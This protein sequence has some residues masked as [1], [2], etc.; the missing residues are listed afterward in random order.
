MDN[1]LL[2]QLTYV[3]YRIRLTI[4]HGERWLM[5]ASRKFRPF[6]PPCKGWLWDLAQCLFHNIVPYSFARRAPAFPLVKMFILTGERF[7]WWSSRMLPVYSIFFIIGRD[8]RAGRVLLLFCSTELPFQIINLSLHGFFK[9]SISRCMAFS[10]HQSLV[11]WLFHHLAHE[12]H[13]FS[14]ENHSRPYGHRA[15]CLLDNLP[16]LFDVQDW[17]VHPID[18]RWLIPLGADLFD[19]DLI[20]S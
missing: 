8:I 20:P 2:F 13:D 16:N 7:A 17:E 15:C 18:E 11:A 19:E 1:H 4:I 14:F 9:S 5:E 6:Y 10:N 3:F 12:L